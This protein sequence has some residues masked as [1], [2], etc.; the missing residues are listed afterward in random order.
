MNSTTEEMIEVLENAGF[1]IEYVPMVRV[2]IIYEENSSLMK[3]FELQDLGEVF[4]R[5][6]RSVQYD[7]TNR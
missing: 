4:T 1:Q 7:T 2:P 6:N 3:D 5:L